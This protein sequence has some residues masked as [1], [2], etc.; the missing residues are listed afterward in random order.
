MH[1]RSTPPRGRPSV[2]LTLR[3]QPDLADLP[4]TW[5]QATPAR[6]RAALDVARSRSAGGWFVVGA[7]AD[8]GA[9]RSRVRTVAGREIALWRAADGSVRASGGACPHLGALL[10]DC[11]VID[12]N[13]VCPWHGFR[14]GDGEPG[15]IP[16]RALDDGALLWV[17]LPGI[18]DVEAP[19][20]TRLVRPAL[21]RSICSVVSLRGTCTPDDV[22]ANR[23]DPWHGAWFH[24]YAFSHLVVDDAA[25]SAAELVVDVTFRLG[26]RIGVP[27][28]ARFWCPDARTVVMEIIEGEGL[29]SVVETHATPLTPPGD[30]APVTV[31]TELVVAHSSRAGFVAARRLAW[32]VR[33]LMRQASRRLWVDDLAYA[34]RRSLLRRRGDPVA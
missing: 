18:D 30:R 26:R 34:E 29:G 31:V 12:G 14:L 20:P 9:A 11:P 32:V 2:P 16:I 19:A 33:P 25:S 6:I 8:L 27:V 22:M 21:D 17:H 3:R 23:L 1:P 10:S 5:R 7:S 4:P 28:R 13:L 24:P 15:W